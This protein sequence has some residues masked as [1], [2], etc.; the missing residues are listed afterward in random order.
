V[1][2]LPLGTDEKAN[3]SLGS[4]SSM[5]ADEVRNIPFNQIEGKGMNQSKPISESGHVRRVKGPEWN[6]LFE[7]IRDSSGEEVK[8]TRIDHGYDPQTP[9]GKIDQG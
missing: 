5:D 8:I 1:A 6:D 3:A 2:V 9:N 7:A 4:G